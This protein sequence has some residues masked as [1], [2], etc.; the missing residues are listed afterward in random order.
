MNLSSIWHDVRIAG[1]SLARQPV[2]W[3]MIAGIL[4]VGIAGTTTVFS[5]FNGVFLRP[6][7]I[8]DQ[9]RVMSLD[10]IDPA[11]G[12]EH[13]VPY[14]RYHTWRQYNQTFEAVAFSSQW[15]ANVSHGGRAEHVGMRYV[16]HQFFDI[17]GI[18]PVL[19]RT[20]TAED[21]R[22]GEPKVVLLSVSLWKRM[23]DSDPAI[24]GRTVCLDDDP[25][26]T[27]VGVL[28]DGVFPDRKDLWCPLRADPDKDDGGLGPMA[29]GR[30]RKGVTVQQARDDLTRIQ[31]GW[32]EQHPDKQ[33]TRLPNVTPMRQAYLRMASQFRFVLFVT[34]GVVVLVSVIACC[35]AASTMLA[36]GTYQSRELAMRATLGATRGRIVQQVLAESLVLSIAASLPG[37]LLSYHVLQVLVRLLGSVVPT[38]MKFPLDIRCILFCV[39]IVAATTILSGLLPALHAAAPKDL[40]GI[41]QALGARTTG[42]RAKRRTL[43]AIIAAQVALA[44][45]LLVAAGL[46]LR[47]Y[48]KVQDIDPGFRTAGVLTYNVPLSIWPNLDEN[49]RHAF[50]DQ[51]IEKVQALPGV[52]HAALINNAPMSYPATKR[53]EAED[54]AQRAGNERNPDV[55]VWR[56][57][58]DYFATVGIPLLAGRGFAESDNRRGSEQTAV[59]D[60]TFA[61]RFWPNESPIDKRVRPRGSQD[62]IR[63]I[64]VV[65]DTKQISLEQSPQPSIYLPRVTDAAYGMCVV[66][67]T[68]GDPLSLVPAIRA[69]MQSID[70]GL[71]IEDIY[72]LAE[73]VYESMSGRRLA[74][75]MYGI[76]ALVAAILAFAGIY[77]VTSYAVSQ[78]TQEIGIRMALGARVPDV[79]T[80]VVGQGL[81]LVVIGL[82]IGLLGAIA[83]GRVLASMEFMLYDVGPAD[84]LTFAG[85]PVL[86]MI[87]SML[88]CYIPARKAAKVDPMTALRCE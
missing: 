36:R 42:S 74:L 17:F 1:R 49:K 53:Y 13:S 7:P 67:Q 9:E 34:L 43:D 47:T 78:R 32:A 87:T 20:F 2:Q 68:S 82:A 8:P 25:A 80:M 6:L 63:V 65:K 3:L 58:P 44:M 16:T 14:Y 41:L 56:I 21:D 66:V 69:S 57:T 61:K 28:P 88:A 37:I 24:V 62:W 83:L 86:L 60:E 31:R 29:A 11:T 15:V 52:V 51:Y 19:G 5:L 38:W 55:L 18:R 35:N 71:P 59:I 81:R 50:W 40:H 46:I 22:P 30:L 4:A 64:G 76:P 12:S 79:T 27:V 75:W 45:T 39:G 73:R 85:V 84:P 77:G 10:E 48:L 70:P 72:T 23:F 54:A 26:F 33:L